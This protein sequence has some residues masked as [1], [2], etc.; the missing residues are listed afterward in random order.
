MP[1]IHFDVGDTQLAPVIGDNADGTNNW[2]GGLT[3]VG[4][5]GPE[6]MNLPRGT[7]IFSNADSMDMMNPMPKDMLS[8]L[9]NS[10]SSSQSPAHTGRG[11]IDMRIYMDSREIARATA[12]QMVGMIKVATGM[13]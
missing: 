4:E 12:P 1:A 8:T 5:E 9:K 2:R 3:W 6:L 13:R 11:D 7:Q 10:A